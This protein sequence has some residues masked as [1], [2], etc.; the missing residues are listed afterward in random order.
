M[1]GLP[2]ARK[3]VVVPFH[4]STGMTILALT[5]ARILWRLT[6]R[7]PPFPRDMAPWERAVAHAAHG[8][9]YALMV[10]MPLIGWM[11]ISS[12]PPRPQGAAMIWGV[13]RLPAIAPIAN[14]ADAAQKTAHGRFVAAHVAGAWILIGL[15]VLHI[16][17]AV[18]HQ[19]FDRQPELARMGIGKA[20]Q[21]GGSA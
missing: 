11:I 17:G 5:A 18:K 16:A 2:Q 8:L 1:E 14:L 4:F 13:L 21:P 7:P 3:A 15:L 10:V 20:A 19:W 9:L 6:H 12:H